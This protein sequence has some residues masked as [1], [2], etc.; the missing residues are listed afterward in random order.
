MSVSKTIRTDL[1]KKIGQRKMYSRM[2]K[3]REIT[4]HSITS[5]TALHVVASQE[6]IPVAKILKKEQKTEELRDFQDA[7]KNFNFNNGQQKNVRH[8]SPMEITP[9]SQTTPQNNGYQSAVIKKIVMVGQKYGIENID[10]DWID[11]LAILNFIETATT[12]FLMEHDYTEEEVKN[13][14]WEEKLTKLQN[15]M[16]EEARIKGVT[17]R[18]SV[19]SFFKSYRDVR[20]DQD[21]VAHLPTSHVTKGE[22]GLLQKNLDMFIAAVFVEHKKYCLK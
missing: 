20:N 21:H 8:S 5:D 12:K 9:L 2:D 10:D 1:I 7:V 22:I 15:K 17:L 19:G 16:Y 14:K 6:K 4:S 18:T 13:M 11:A 3:V